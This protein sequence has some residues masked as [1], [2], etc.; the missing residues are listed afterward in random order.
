MVERLGSSCVA[1]RAPHQEEQINLRSA[2]VGS[3]TL[4]SLKTV[5]MEG[6]RPGRA[7]REL[8]SEKL[9]GLSCTGNAFCSREGD[10]EVWA[11]LLTASEAGIKR[12]RP[13]ATAG[14]WLAGQPHAAGVALKS[15]SLC[16]PHLLP[17]CPAAACGSW[18]PGQWESQRSCQFVG[19]AWLSWSQVLGMKG[20]S[21][22]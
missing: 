5:W 21:S 12:G 11:R 3:L 15:H 7:G 4:L 8:C 19:L 6:G 13:A 20:R 2:L 14:G 1:A 17:L 9:L 16:V 18:Q 22:I 10:E